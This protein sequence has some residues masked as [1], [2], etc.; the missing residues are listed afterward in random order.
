MLLLE[1]YTAY[2]TD[3]SGL[4]RLCDAQMMKTILG[5]H[6]N[7]AVHLLQIRVTSF[8]SLGYNIDSNIDKESKSFSAQKLI[9]IKESSHPVKTTVKNRSLQQVMKKHIELYIINFSNHL[10]TS[11]L[12]QLVGDI[13]SA[14]AEP[15]YSWKSSGERWRP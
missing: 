10:Q 8:C 6:P 7:L 2:I 4:N 9:G 13:L 14:R 3:V 1:A 12:P 11:L 5:Q 15:V